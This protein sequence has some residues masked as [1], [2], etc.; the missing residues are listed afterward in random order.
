MTLLLC[1]LLVGAAQAQDNES[2]Q[3]PVTAPAMAIPG[4]QQEGPH[5]FRSEQGFLVMDTVQRDGVWHVVS[6]TL[7]A[8][9]LP[10]IV[11]RVDNAAHTT[12]EVDLRSNPGPATAE[13]DRNPDRLLMLSDLEGQFDKSVAL[14]QATDVIDA[15]LHWQ[16]GKDHV[17]LV[18]DQV[19][20]GEQSTAL[21][22]LLYRLDAEATAAGGGLHL[23]LGNH[24]HMLLSGRSKYWAPRQV[25]FAS[26]LGAEGQHKLYGAQSVL[27]GWL[28]SKNVIARIGDHL[29][30]HGG[31]SHA[32]LSAG[33]NLA[34]ANR[35]ARPHLFT[36]LQFLPP[37][38]AV[39]LGELGVTWYRGMA[40]PD[41]PMF[42][43]ESDPKAHLEQVLATYGAKRLA[44][45]HTIVPHIGLEQSGRLLRLDID[46]AEQ[47]PEAAL[48]EAGALWRVDAAGGRTQLDANARSPD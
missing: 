15:S 37:E 2:R 35:I 20:R 3:A 33:L 10:R 27:G 14:L 39:V 23:I 28:A 4:L 6:E 22:W 25:A 31:I 24:E 17:A 40:L 26:A 38:A 9:P 34:E 5:V 12:F 13:V 21:L 44:I 16:Y 18:G 7:P 19:D 47:L 29:L 41:D 46:H 11:V 42:V 36:D 32:F 1:G 48:Y 43:R 8:E 30:V 45:G